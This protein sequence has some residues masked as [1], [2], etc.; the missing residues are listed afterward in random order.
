MFDQK[1]YGQLI[2]EWYKYKEFSEVK[3]SDEYIRLSA[4]KAQ[5]L[6]GGKA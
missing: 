6:D 2:N 1:R 5:F 4:R 3:L